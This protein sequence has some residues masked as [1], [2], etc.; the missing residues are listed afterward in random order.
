LHPQFRAQGLSKDAELGNPV[1]AIEGGDHQS[2]IAGASSER[3]RKHQLDLR[4]GR[5]RR[6]REGLIR[7]ALNH[8]RTEH[9]RL[10]LVFSKHQ[11]RQIEAAPE[12]V[13]DACLAA[14]RHPRERQIP[15]VSVDGALGHLQLG[16]EP[17]R[18]DEPARPQELN[19]AK[20]SIGS[21]HRCQG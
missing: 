19:Q 8:P 18:G 11:R 7:V 12:R 13:P 4:Q 17:V 20:Q 16:G 5:V 14:N 1:A 10:E 6:S 15:N 3:I 21:P 9:Q 2:R